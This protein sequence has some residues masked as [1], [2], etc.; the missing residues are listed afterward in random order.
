MASIMQATVTGSTPRRTGRTLARTG[1]AITA[2]VALFLAFD[3]ATHAARVPAVVQG[4]HADGFPISA[5]LALGVFELLCVA[6][7]LFPRT[8]VLGAILLTG[9]LGGAVCV[10]VRIEAPLL[11]GVLGPV[12][13]ATVM[14][15]ALY[16]R[17]SRL[18][19]LLSLRG[20]Q[21]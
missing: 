15:T 19:A 1:W 17:E 16:L 21:A 13:V 20:R 12:Y 8:A 9:Y 14:W 10:E 7:Y 11:A 3:G 5:A 4:F 18:R 2:L 6:L